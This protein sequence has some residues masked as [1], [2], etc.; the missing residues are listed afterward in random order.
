MI[1]GQSTTPL[2]TGPLRAAPTPVAAEPVLTMNK[3]AF[4]ASATAPLAAQGSNKFDVGAASENLIQ[5]EHGN[6]DNAYNRSFNLRDMEP[7]DAG[8]QKAADAVTGKV[9]ALGW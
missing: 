8:Y 9:T 2:P 5:V 1:I 4:K 6:L 3:D 7:T